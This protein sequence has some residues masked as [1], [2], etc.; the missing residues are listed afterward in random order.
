MKDFNLYASPVN[1]G[2]P[3]WNSDV[4]SAWNPGLRPSSFPNLNRYRA[5]NPNIRE[6]VSDTLSMFYMPKFDGRYFVGDSTQDIIKL[7]D[8]IYPNLPKS[9]QQKIDD[10]QTQIVKAVLA[11]KASDATQ[12]A[13]GFLG[14]PNLVLIGGA[15]LLYMLITHDKRRR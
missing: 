10:A 15:A 6:R 5:T 7:Y 3:A 12:K 13:V 8:A 2:V 14:N 9:Y 4:P 11:K 1:F